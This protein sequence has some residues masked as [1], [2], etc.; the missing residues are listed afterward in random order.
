[1]EELNAI[2]RKCLGPLSFGVLVKGQ[3]FACDICFYLILGRLVSWIIKN[4][5]DLKI[6]SILTVESTNQF[7]S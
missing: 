5:V 1:V 6:G 7:Q 3:V 2:E 4:I